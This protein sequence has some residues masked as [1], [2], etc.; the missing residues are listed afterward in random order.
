MTDNPEKSIDA[1]RPDRTW[2]DAHYQEV[3]RRFEALMN[4]P[5]PVFL[6]AMPVPEPKVEPGT[7]YP[8][9]ERTVLVE[10]TPGR[11][12]FHDYFR[13]PMVTEDMLNGG[14]HVGPEVQPEGV[15]SPKEVMA[16]IRG[17]IAD[18]IATGDAVLLGGSPRVVV[19]VLTPEEAAVAAAMEAVA[20]PD[21]ASPKAMAR[22]A[23]DALDAFRAAPK[24]PARDKIPNLRAT[25]GNGPP[26]AHLSAAWEDGE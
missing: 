19:E 6:P 1:P 4:F 18:K 12:P 24:P 20:G 2:L 7:F 22:A 13:R 23:I 15:L 17:I 9:E 3:R 8:K 11:D 16:K 14:V 21:G 25:W 5:P 10:T 26:A